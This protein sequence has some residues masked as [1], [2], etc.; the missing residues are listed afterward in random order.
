LKADI[1]AQLKEREAFLKAIPKAGQDII[2]PEGEVVNI[3]PPSKS[4]IT[5]VTV[6][7]K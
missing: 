6:K 1:D 2:T 4:S 7:L 3:F 5:S